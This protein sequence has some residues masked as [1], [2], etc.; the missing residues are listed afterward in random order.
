MWSRLCI[1]YRYEF[2]KG[3]R[4]SFCAPVSAG[5][6]AIAARARHRDPPD[7]RDIAALLHHVPHVAV[8]L[9]GNAPDLI[10][11][12]NRRATLPGG[13]VAGEPTR[14]IFNGAAVTQR[15]WL[16]DLLTNLAP[17]MIQAIEIYN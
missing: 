3:L 8:N 1:E 10:T 15:A 11:P 5:H 2:H 7:T 6:T 16:N 4:W 9:D 13:E 17:S 14:V 12:A